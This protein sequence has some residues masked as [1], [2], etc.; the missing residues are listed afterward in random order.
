M[1]G[2]GGRERL[3]E[4]GLTLAA[5]CSAVT[6]TSSPAAPASDSCERGT[7]SKS[8]ATGGAAAAAAGDCIFLPD[9]M[10]R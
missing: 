10:I 9:Q 1:V 7:N 8:S 3:S 4:G 2:G 5:L 6:V